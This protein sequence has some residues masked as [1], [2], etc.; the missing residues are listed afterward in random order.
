MNSE[1]LHRIHVPNDGDI[2]GQCGAADHALNVT[3][4]GS[5]FGGTQQQLEALLTVR[6]GQG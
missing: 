2:G 4:Q 3:R 6:L 5:H 1:E